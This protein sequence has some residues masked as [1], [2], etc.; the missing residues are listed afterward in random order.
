MRVLFVCAGNTCRSPMAEALCRHL[1]AARGMGGRVQA[2][3]VGV[4]AHNG[5]PVN[6]QALAVLAGHGIAHHGVARRITPADFA[7]SDLI[8][9]LDRRVVAALEA[10]R[11]AGNETPVKLLMDY[12]PQAGVAE[13]F[14]PYGTDRYEEAFALIRQG[15][16]GLLAAL[17]REGE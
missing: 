3:S 4:S 5:D 12:A 10:M 8:L 14:D 7:A 15:V 1:A 17:E 6:P 11:P 2:A 9:A 13:V 16:E